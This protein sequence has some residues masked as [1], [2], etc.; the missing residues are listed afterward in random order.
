MSQLGSALMLTTHSAQR[1]VSGYRVSS[2]NN[3]KFNG[4]THFLLHL[5]TAFML[6]RTP[7]RWEHLYGYIIFNESREFDRTL[8]GAQTL[9][10]VILKIR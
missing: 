5:T 9:G 4:I 10:Y 3:C 7:Y 2:L 8:F 6:K 1:D